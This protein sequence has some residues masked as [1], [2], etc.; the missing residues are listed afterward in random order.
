[1]PNN[2]P[3]FLK[4]VT[5]KTHLKDQLHFF[6]KIIFKIGVLRILFRRFIARISRRLAVIFSG[7]E[8]L[9]NY[10]PH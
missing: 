1:L 5:L 3:Q 2:G 10:N 7:R 8:K 4:G 9:A 6:K